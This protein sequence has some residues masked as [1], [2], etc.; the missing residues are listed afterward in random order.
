MLL[1]DV[2]RRSCEV[3]IDGDTWLVERDGLSREAAGEIGV[4]GP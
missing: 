2:R 3:A 1:L 4:E